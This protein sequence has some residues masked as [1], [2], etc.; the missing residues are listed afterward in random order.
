MTE[1]EKISKLSKLLG[2][3]E[4]QAVRCDELN[5]WGRIETR[6]AFLEISQN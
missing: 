2:D 3:V 5:P 6:E 4:E 1:R